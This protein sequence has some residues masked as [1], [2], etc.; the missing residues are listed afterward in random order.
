MVP[1]LELTATESGPVPTVMVPVTTG[2]PKTGA[3]TA[4]GTATARTRAPTA[5]A[6][7]SRPLGWRQAADTR[8]PDLVMWSHLLPR[9]SLAPRASRNTPES[10][11]GYRKVPA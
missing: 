9:G 11:S 10:P 8:T 5:P 7:T 6:D 3:A 2:P 4:D 1:L